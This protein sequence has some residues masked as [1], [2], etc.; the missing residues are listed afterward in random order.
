MNIR[1]SLVEEGLSNYTLHMLSKEG[2]LPAYLSSGEDYKA[3]VTLETLRGTRIR[4]FELYR[5]GPIALSE[6]SPGNLMYANS[7]VFTNSYFEFQANEESI[8]PLLFTVQNQR[9][10]EGQLETLGFEEDKPHYI[11]SVPLANLQMRL[12]GRVDSDDE[13]EIKLS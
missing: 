6:F 3:E 4:N 12:V 2:F 10:E 1:R 9:I 11:Y 5:N 7:A 13:L 8:D